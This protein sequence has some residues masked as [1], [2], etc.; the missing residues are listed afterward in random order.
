MAKNNFRKWVT[1]DI[2]C[3]AEVQLKS[4]VV[5]DFLIQCDLFEFNEILASVK[6]QVNQP[7]IEGMTINTLSDQMKFELLINAFNKYSIFELEEK[8]K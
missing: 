8:L 2:D 6:K 5:I 7:A 4:G 1:V 3:E